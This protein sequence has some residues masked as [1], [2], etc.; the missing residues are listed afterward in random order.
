[1]S[2]GKPRVPMSCLLILCLL[3]LLAF[4]LFKLWLVFHQL[5]DDLGEHTFERV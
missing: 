2:Q 5:A 3:L 1:M 4:M